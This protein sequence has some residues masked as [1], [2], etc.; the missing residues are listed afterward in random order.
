MRLGMARA[1]WPWASGGRCQ[2]RRREPGSRMP[3][4]QADRRLPRRSRARHRQ[5]QMP[6]P[7]AR[8]GDRPRVVSSH[9]AKGGLC[10]RAADHPRHL[11]PAH[12]L[13]RVLLDA[14]PGWTRVRDAAAAPDELRPAHVRI[15]CVVQPSRRR[16]SPIRTQDLHRHGGLPSFPR[17][18][19]VT[20][21][22][23]WSPRS[24]CAE[25]TRRP[26]QIRPRPFGRGVPPGLA[27]G[28]EPEQ[29]RHVDSRADAGCGLSTMKRQ[30]SDG[31]RCGLGGL[32]PP[33]GEHAKPR[34]PAII[35][36][37]GIS[38]CDAV[39]QAGRE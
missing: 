1:A 29:A 2:R 7:T 26:R 37:S 19:F 34:A 18:D 12:D 23:P 25:E 36:V 39:S 9:P 11:R 31:A 28:G 30:V 5:D 22:A 17:A 8:P 33:A 35:K 6:Q 24:A 13:R 16:L 15:V 38:I 27:V 20:S 21:G 3:L 32:A 14:R 4:S 10:G